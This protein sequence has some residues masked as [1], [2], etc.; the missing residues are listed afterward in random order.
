MSGAQR[1]WNCRCGA[2]SAAEPQNLS[3]TVLKCDGN[4]RIKEA[5]NCRGLLRGLRV[6]RA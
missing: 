1:D 4:G 2:P 3:S 6:F 5:V